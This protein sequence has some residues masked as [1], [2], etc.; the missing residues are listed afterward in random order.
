MI[1]GKT[2]WFG[3]VAAA[4]L[5]AAGCG[6]DSG[7]GGSP[8]MG[9]MGGSGPAG[10]N[11][12]AV[13][14]APEVPT[15]EDTEVV[16]FVDGTQIP[17]VTISYGESTGRVNVPAGTYEIGLGVPGME[18]LTLPPVTLADG[19]DFTAVA[20]RNNET[21]PLGVF[22][23]DNAADGLEGDDGRVVVA[24]G[25]ND[26]LLDP[27][28]IILT[29]EGACPDPLLDQF[30][31]GTFAPALD[32]PE[33]NYN[34]GFDLDPG[35]CEAEVKFSAPVTPGVTSILVAV[36]ED[37]T[38]ESLDPQVWAIVD[39]SDTPLPLIEEMQ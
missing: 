36:D 37:T 9:G 28:D 30:A 15:A 23:I 1:N 16:I 20:Y 8:G 19:D 26:S 34:L 35:D 21:L 12:T 13:H 22:L 6:D 18:L 17:G 25:A 38:D 27:V 3:L 29:D 11:V 7:S 39:A 5:A 10:A 4:A 2:F 31:F 33:A 24:H 14:L 32:L